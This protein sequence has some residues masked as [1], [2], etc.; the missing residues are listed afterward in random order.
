M[1]LVVRSEEHLTNIA[2]QYYFIAKLAERSLEHQKTGIRIPPSAN[3]LTN[4]IQ[5]LEKSKIKK[6]WPR[7]DGAVKHFVQREMVGAAE[8]GLTDSGRRLGERVASVG[9]YLHQGAS[10]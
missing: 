4:I 2:T 6:N 1:H 9:T 5:L 10:I 8:P 7:M 3:L